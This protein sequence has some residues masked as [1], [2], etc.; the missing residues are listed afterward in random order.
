MK[1]YVDLQFCLNLYKTEA[2]SSSDKKNIMMIVNMLPG[3]GV[4]YPT[5]KTSKSLKTCKSVAKIRRNLTV[6]VVYNI[7]GT[8][9]N[10]HIF[11]SFILKLFRYL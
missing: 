6:Y 11:N 10:I 5:P 2:M 3:H 1:S 8:F 9:Q 4:T 7:K